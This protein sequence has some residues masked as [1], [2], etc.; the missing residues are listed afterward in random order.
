MSREH[1]MYKRQ[2]RKIRRGGLIP[3]S[4]LLAN[5]RRGSWRSKRR[6]RKRE[7]EQR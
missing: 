6:R 7:K 2:A 1:R 3:N 4:A 5:I